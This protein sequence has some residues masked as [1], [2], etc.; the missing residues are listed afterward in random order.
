MPQPCSTA[1]PY[2]SRNASISS[3]GAAEPP[4]M[5]RF[6]VA[7][8]SPL[9]RRCLQQAE[10]D[11]RHAAAHRHALLVEQPREAGAIEVATRQH[12]RRAGQRRGIRDA[13]GVDVEHRHDRQDAVGG[14]QVRARRAARSH[15]RGAPWSGGCTARPSAARWC[16]TCSRARWRCSRRTPARRSRRPPRPSAR[17]SRAGASPAGSVQRRHRRRVGHHHHGAHA[18][19]D[20]AA[21]CRRSAAAKPGS[22][23]STLSPAWLMM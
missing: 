13:P 11:G 22:T 1:T 8:F 21:R 14:A 15:R 3:G 20:P 23:N 17:R 2:S 19:G 4:V 7:S 9:A 5:M 12:Q 16:P 6:T 18:V 10:P